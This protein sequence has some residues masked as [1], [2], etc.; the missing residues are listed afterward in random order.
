MPRPTWSDRLTDYWCRRGTESW[1]DL[2]AMI[3]LAAPSDCAGCAVA[4]SRWCE[5]CDA[6]LTGTPPRQWWPTPSPPGM[7]ATWT[8][9][10]Y[11]G[12][13]RAAVVA[14]KEQDRVHLTRHLAPV[15]GAGV[16]AAVRGSVEHQQALLRGE[17]IAVVP[18]PS[19]RSSSRARGREPVRELA[20][21]A[22]GRGAVVQGLVL[23]RRVRDQAGLSAS[24]RERNLAGAIIVR[25]GVRSLLRGVPCVVVDDVVTTGATLQE[26]ARALAQ[27]GAGP[28]VAAT[29]AA[30]A[31][32]AVPMGDAPLSPTRGA[33]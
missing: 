4:G 24:E 19:A 11:Q 21:A 29:V 28:V 31:R 12:P 32:R 13:V 25:T 5:R 1:S 10:A 2:R 23:H 3:E 14:W 16:A 30:T 17:P 22:C 6:E 33:D 26:C 8:G 9:P 7:P 20:G 15:L 18:A 27:A